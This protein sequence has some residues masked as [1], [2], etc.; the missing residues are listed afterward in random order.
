[1]ERTL[2]APPVPKPAPTTHLHTDRT[3]MAGRSAVVDRSFSVL[4]KLVQETFR[5]QVPSGPIVGQTK[6]KLVV[7]SLPSLKLEACSCHRATMT[8]TNVRPSHAQISAAGAISFRCNA[9][10][11]P[12]PP[13]PETMR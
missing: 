7:P 9:Y 10:E 12:R 5:A 11:V 4:A 13:W 6:K 3:R 1:M 8:S 2:V